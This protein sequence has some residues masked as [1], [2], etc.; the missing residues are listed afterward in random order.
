VLSRDR[1]AVTCSLFDTLK[2]DCVTRPSAMFYSGFESG[3]SASRWKDVRMQSQAWF[4]VACSA[5]AF[6]AT[7]ARA[8]EPGVCR[9]SAANRPNNRYGNDRLSVSVWRDGTVIFRPGGPGFVLP[10]GALSMKF[11]WERGVR[12]SLEIK[13]RRLDGAAAPLRAVIPSGYGD[14]GFQASALVF[15]TP[16]C[17]EV[18]G[19]VGQETL[20]FVTRVVKIGDGPTGQ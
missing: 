2:I 12:G 5:A 1:A 11:G 10:D 9:T 17:W 13:G 3:P 7:E 14:I 4:L 15:P 20:T 18:I 16:G 8:V 6:V 19:S